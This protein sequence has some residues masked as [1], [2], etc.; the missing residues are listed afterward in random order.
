MFWLIVLVSPTVVRKDGWS[1]GVYLALVRR[2]ER[3]R[4]GYQ[5]SRWLLEILGI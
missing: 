4:L 3:Q 5:P 1:K 2:K